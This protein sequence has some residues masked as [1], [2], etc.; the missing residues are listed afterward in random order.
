MPSGAAQ[1]EL[2]VKERHFKSDNTVTVSLIR[3]QEK[4]DKW[5]LQS[6]DWHWGAQ[7]FIKKLRQYRL[8]EKEIHSHFRAQQT[9][10]NPQPALTGSCTP[11]LLLTLLQRKIFD[12][13]ISSQTNTESKQ[14]ALP[15]GFKGISTFLPWLLQPQQD[16]FR[17][18]LGVIKVLDEK[19]YLL[20]LL[21]LQALKFF[22]QR[23]IFRSQ[24]LWKQTH[25]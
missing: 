23:W 12:R 21:N 22:S 25:R 16:S 6:V 13:S 8:L 10:T 3:H 15:T 7:T 4:G 1:A 19:Y 24:G 11:A 9:Q 17:F 5:H 18:S 2:D 14:D 20:R